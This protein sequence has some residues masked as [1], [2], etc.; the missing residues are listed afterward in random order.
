MMILSRKKNGK[1]INQNKFP[2]QPLQNLSTKVD[3][4]RALY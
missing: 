2:G 1:T 3:E 4:K